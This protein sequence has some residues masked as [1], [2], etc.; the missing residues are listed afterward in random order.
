MTHDEAAID[1]EAA[2]DRVSRIIGGNNAD[3]PAEPKPQGPPPRKPRSDKGKSKPPKPV[4]APADPGISAERARELA[5][6]LISEGHLRVA[7]MI[8]EAIEK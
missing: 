6:D 1:I 4:P 7:I 8:L 2:R 3:M 5:K